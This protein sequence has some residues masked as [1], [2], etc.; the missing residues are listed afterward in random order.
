MSQPR[1]IALD[2]M[3]GDFGPEV[4]VPA[5]A[6]ALVRHPPLSFLMFGDE[7]HVRPVLAKHAALAAKCKLTHSD[8]VV[9]MSDKPSQA[10][11]RGKGSSMWLAL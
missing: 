7:H 9:A 11:R 1:I 5:A 8:I 2:A 3:G 10:V 6:L 4:V